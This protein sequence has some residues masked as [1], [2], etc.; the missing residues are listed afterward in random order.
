MWHNQLALAY[1]SKLLTESK[2]VVGFWGRTL[3][4]SYAVCTWLDENALKH[5]AES[6]QACECYGWLL[7]S[8]C[9]C[10]FIAWLQK[11]NNRKQPNA[12]RSWHV[13]PELSCAEISTWLAAQVRILSTSNQKLVS[14]VCKARQLQNQ[15]WAS[16]S[17]LLTPLPSWNGLA[18]ATQ[19]IQLLFVHCS[20]FV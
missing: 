8:F 7:T 19:V 18:W 5:D 13:P 16:D 11:Q 9:Q 10:L 17:S 14:K 6:D 20:W 3:Q 15:T 12:I 1:R 2:L 4:D